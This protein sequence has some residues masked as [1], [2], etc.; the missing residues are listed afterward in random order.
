LD[1]ANIPPDFQRDIFEEIANSEWEQYD[2]CYGRESET[3]RDELEIFAGE[4]QWP[5]NADKRDAN[6]ISDAD[7]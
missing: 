2:N 4:F 5:K 3:A 6:L 7:K 1:V